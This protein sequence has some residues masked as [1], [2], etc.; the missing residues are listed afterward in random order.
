MVT[1]VAFIQFCARVG[2][3]PPVVDAR[4]AHSVVV[5]SAMIASRANV[6]KTRGGVSVLVTVPWK[7]LLYGSSDDDLVVVAAQTDSLALTECVSGTG[8]S[9][10]LQGDVIVWLS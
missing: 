10:H 3:V 8:T 6:S 1:I 4:V 2:A 5:V 9:A 7:V